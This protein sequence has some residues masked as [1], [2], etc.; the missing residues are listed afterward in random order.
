MAALV[1]GVFSFLGFAVLLPIEAYSIF[2]A[3]SLEAA[4]VT[5]GAGLL[6]ISGFLANYW[7]VLVPPAQLL[8]TWY[9]TAQVG[10]CWAHIC[11]AP[12]NSSF[13]PKWKDPHKLG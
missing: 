7:W 6:R 2:I 10:R 11:T 12:S 5:H 3:P 13:K 8:L 1:Y 9:M 4:N